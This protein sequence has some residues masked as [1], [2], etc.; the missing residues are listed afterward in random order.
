MSTN[1]NNKSRG[2]LF[3]PSLNDIKKAKK[4]DLNTALLDEDGLN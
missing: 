1:Y 4:K 2:S 3:F